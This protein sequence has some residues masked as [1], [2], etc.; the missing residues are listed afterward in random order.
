M[1]ANYQLPYLNSCIQEV[2]LDCI[3]ICARLLN[4]STLCSIKS[5]TISI[6]FTGISQG[7]EPSRFSIKYLF[8]E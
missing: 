4:V 8:I 1:G 7:Q 5:E 6:V 3:Y 2:L